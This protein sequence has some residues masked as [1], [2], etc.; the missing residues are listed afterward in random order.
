MLA[1]LTLAV[2]ASV[3]LARLLA[4]APPRRRAAVLALVTAGVLADGWIEPLPLHETPAAIAVPS[5]PSRPAT[6]LELPTGVFEDAAAMYRAT[7]H[8]QRIANGLSGHAPPHYPALQAAM[9]ESRFEVIAEL[10]AS[11]VL[12]VVDRDAAGPAVVSA[13]RE[14]AGGEVVSTTVSHEVV[15]IPGAPPSPGASRS[16]RRL[17]IARLQTSTDPR[18]RALAI[19]GDFRT[20]WTTTAPQAGNETVLADLGSVTAIGSVS[21]GMGAH[22]VSYPR[23]AAID[24]SGD[25]VAWTTVWRGGTAA[26]AVRAAIDDPRT[27]RIPIAFDPVEARYVR[28]RQLATAAH[29]WAVA[30]LEVFAPR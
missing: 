15:R 3:A 5:D 23:E 26:R 25:G 7:R 4:A 20:A 14:L 19:D 9:Q 8:G 13:L 6:V 28:I 12:V 21:L 10:S 1:A 30:E 2:A 27:A 24:V 22:A 18:D 11:A 29:P 16:G 17:P